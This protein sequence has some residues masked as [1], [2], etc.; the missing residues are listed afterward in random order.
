[1]NQW[2]YV[3]ISRFFSTSS[4]FL[5]FSLILFLILS[6]T[7]LS[8]VVLPSNCLYWSSVLHASPLTF[9]PLL[10]ILLPYCI[11]SHLKYEPSC[12]VSLHIELL[13]SPPDFLAFP[14]NHQMS[15]LSFST[16]G[17]GVI[18]GEFSPHVLVCSLLHLHSL[19]PPGSFPSAHKPA[20]VSPTLLNLKQ[21]NK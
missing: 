1:M 15:R 3:T 21:V 9:D 6:E 19:L 16:P 10:P 14:H 2:L 18:L 8:L 17:L 5:D 4:S 12:W 20:S 13:C 11:Y 7:H